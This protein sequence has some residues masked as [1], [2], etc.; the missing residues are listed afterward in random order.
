MAET[1]ASNFWVFFTFVVALGLRLVPWPHE[2]ALAS[3]DWVALNLMF[4]VLYSEG[5]VGVISAWLIGILTDAVTGH[6]LGQ[7]GLA[8]AVMAYLLM[9]W[10]KPISFHPLPQQTLV[11]AGVLLVGHLLVLWTERIVPDGREMAWT[12]I[13]PL[14]GAILWLTLTLLIRGKRTDPA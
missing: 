10:S 12:W 6:L 2:M 3:P 11:L 8:Y 14:S 7:Y 13:S 9:R 1:R 4:W 5:R